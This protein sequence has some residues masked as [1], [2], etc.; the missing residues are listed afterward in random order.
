MPPIVAKIVAEAVPLRGSVV[1]VDVAMSVVWQAVT[2]RRKLSW[3]MRCE[4]IERGCIQ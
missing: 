1:A 4:F 3:R 2:T